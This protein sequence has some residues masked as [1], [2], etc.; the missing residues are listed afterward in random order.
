MQRAGT[1]EPRAASSVTCSLSGIWRTS[2][3]IGH[4]NSS[5]ALSST[6]LILPATTFD[7]APASGKYDFSLVRIKEDPKHSGNAIALIQSA[8]HFQVLSA[9][10]LQLT[11]ILS[12]FL[13]FAFPRRSARGLEVGATRFERA[14]SC[15]QS[16]RSTKLSYAPVF[17]KG[18]NM[19]DQ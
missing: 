18:A 14:T 3:C 9:T 17:R 19:N 4:G 11:R 15:S 10:I 1:L 16:R 2:G 6:L 8:L 5:S 12:E 7:A 13:S